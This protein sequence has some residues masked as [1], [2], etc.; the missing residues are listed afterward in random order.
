M[1]S[2]AVGVEFASIFRRFGSEV[3]I[4]ELLPRLV[5]IEDEAVSAELERSFKKQG[6][7]V[8]TGTKVTSA[9]PA[10]DGVDL[11]AQADGRRQIEAQRGLPAGRHRARPGHERPR[12]R[13]ARAA[14]G[15]RL[16]PRRSRV[17]DQRA[18]HLRDRRRHHLRSA[19]ASAAGAPLVGRR[20]RRSPSGSPARS[21]G[22]S[23]TTRCRLHLLRSGDRQRRPDRAGGEGA[24]LRRSRRHVQVRRARRAR[25]ADETEGS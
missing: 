12:R 3:T 16:H 11:E 19:R 20:H 17:P 13:R 25:I 8:L 21:R 10:T 5:P 22:R 6:I 15:A 7:K 9:R 14:D 1:G 23:T 4:I 24:R 2:G 18:G